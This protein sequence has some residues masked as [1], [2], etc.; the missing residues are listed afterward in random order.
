MM[1]TPTGTSLTRNT[2]AATRRT[3]PPIVNS[4]AIGSQCVT[5]PAIVN[6]HPPGPRRS[7]AGRPSSVIGGVGCGPDGTLGLAGH[8]VPLDLPEMEALD[9]QLERVPAFGQAD[10]FDHELV[11]RDDP[12]TGIAGLPVAGATPDSRNTVEWQSAV[13]EFLTD[14]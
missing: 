9:V 2:E 7:G 3:R 10:A 14:Q 6:A 11:F 5:R 8:G 12:L 4:R 1:R 13:G